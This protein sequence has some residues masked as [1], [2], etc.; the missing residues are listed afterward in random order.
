MRRSGRGARIALLA[1]VLAAAAAGCDG[2]DQENIADRVPRTIVAPRGPLVAPA[3]RAPDCGGT[4]AMQRAART[5]ALSQRALIWSPFGRPEFGW[6]IYGP[7]IAR[8]VGTVCPSDSAGF[9][10]ALANWQSA[11]R[12]Y[13]DGLVTPATFEVLK[14]RWHARRPYVSLRAQGVCPDPPPPGRLA[15]AR[16][17]EGYRGKV[18]MLRPAALDALRRMQAAARA[19]DPA[20]ARDPQMLTIFSAYRDPAADA[21]QCATEGNCDGVA[22]A[23]CSAH[24]TGLAVDL[25][26]GNAPGYPV[27]SS[28][29][30]NRLFMSRTPAYRWMVANAGRF[31][32]VNYVFEPW[33]WEYVREPIQIAPAGYRLGPGASSTPNAAAP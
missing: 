17:E 32:F 9:A 23:R 27:D 5:N 11:N 16:V 4:P 26:V 19:E 8:E 30:P 25:V 31:G 14:A 33:H 18:V 20:I 13:V 28:A 10:Q 15:V 24:R 2:V 7:Q 6:E 12:L 22:R 21:A 1:A 29:V 3:P